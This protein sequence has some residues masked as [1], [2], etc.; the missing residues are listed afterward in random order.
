MRNVGGQQF[1][2]RALTGRRR[3][4]KSEG[5]ATAQANERRAEYYRMSGAD[6]GESVFSSAGRLKLNFTSISVG[7]RGEKSG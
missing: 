6:A 5:T 3:E 2:L 4:N 7:Q 1:V